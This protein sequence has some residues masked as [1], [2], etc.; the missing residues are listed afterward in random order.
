[1][2]PAT[3]TA[4]AITKAATPVLFCLNVSVS[5]TGSAVTVTPGVA[6]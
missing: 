2:T 4:K 5:A 3:M 1:M 6:V